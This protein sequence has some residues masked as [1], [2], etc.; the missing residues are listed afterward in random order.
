MAVTP[1]TIT[2]IAMGTPLALPAYTSVATVAD[3]AT[4][5]LAG[6]PA[7]DVLVN[8]KFSASGGSSATAVSITAG[9]N[10]PAFRA[11]LG[12]VAY[13]TSG[14]VANSEVLFA[15]GDTARLMQSTGKIEIAFDQTTTGSVQTASVRA[16][17]L[18]R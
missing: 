5:D 8:V 18:P 2:D 9:D 1:I 15:I 14:S 17:R 4:I 16:F 3:G 13:A 11:G 12:D 6:V 7:E 10:P